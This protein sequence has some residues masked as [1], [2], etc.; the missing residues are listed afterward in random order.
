MTPPTRLP[1]PNLHRTPLRRPL[2]Q[3]DEHLDRHFRTNRRVRERREK[4]DRES[5]V[6]FGGERV[7]QGSWVVGGGG[8]GGGVSGVFFDGWKE[9]SNGMGMRMGSVT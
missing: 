7:V 4:E 5:G 9:G 3:M 1:N 2:P 8:G 6:V